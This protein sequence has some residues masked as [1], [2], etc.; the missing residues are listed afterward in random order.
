[1]IA[2]EQFRDRSVPI[3]FPSWRLPVAFL[4]DPFSEARGRILHAACSNVVKE[5][6]LQA[7]T[8]Q[9]LVGM[10]LEIIEGAVDF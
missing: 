6:P 9:E 4:L 2:G 5:Q 10:G 7:C 1:M 8:K 3:Y